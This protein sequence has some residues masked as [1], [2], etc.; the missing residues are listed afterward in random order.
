MKKINLFSA[1]KKMT[2][3]VLAAAAMCSILTLTGCSNSTSPIVSNISPDSSTVSKNS[4][5]RDIKKPED[6]TDDDFNEFNQIAA[7]ELDERVKGLL[8]EGEDNLGKGVSKLDIIYSIDPPDA[9]LT[10]NQIKIKSIDNVKFLSAHMFADMNT[11]YKHLHSGYVYCDKYFIV[12]LFSADI[13]AEGTV[14]RIPG[15]NIVQNAEGQYV[16]SV[17]FGSPGYVDDKLNYKAYMSSYNQSMRKENSMVFKGGVSEEE[18][19]EVWNEKVKYDD[20]CQYTH[21]KIK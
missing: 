20:E 5:K 2:S 11:N 18:A 17:Y 12:L 7:D 1:L 19:L 15:D 21:T 14:L 8:D 4:K 6:L 13:S 9:N 16:F 3:I 10:Y